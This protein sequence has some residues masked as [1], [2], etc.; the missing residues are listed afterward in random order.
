MV[1]GSAPGSGAFKIKT[2]EL[3]ERILDERG[4]SGGSRA[5]EITSWT[6]TLVSRLCDVKENGYLD[7]KREAK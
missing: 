2:D 4:E 7:W 6:K 1:E 3:V 5:E